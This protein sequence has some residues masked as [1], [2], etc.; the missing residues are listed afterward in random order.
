MPNSAQTA[1][2]TSAT[3]T[4]TLYSHGRIYYGRY[5]SISIKASQHPRGKRGSGVGTSVAGL[6]REHAWCLL[7]AACSLSGSAGL[8][9][10]VLFV[11]FCLFAALV[12]SLRFVCVFCLCPFGCSLVWLLCFLFVPFCL[13]VLTYSCFLVCAILFTRCHDSL[14]LVIC[15]LFVSFSLLFLGGWQIRTPMRMCRILGFVFVYLDKFY[16]CRT[17]SFGTLIG[18]LPSLYLNLRRLT[19][20]FDTL[21]VCSLAVYRGLYTCEYQCTYYC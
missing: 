15:Y 11:P 21:F 7:A 12:C 2:P 18:L 17:F 10:T 3:A 14:W 16:C 1:S 5:N 9:P 19:L 4:Y 13:F 20:D 8:A 6:Q